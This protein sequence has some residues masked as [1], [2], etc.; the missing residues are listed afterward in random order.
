MFAA[1]YSYYKGDKNLV[2]AKGWLVKSANLNYYISARVL[3]EIY[4]SEKNST[5]AIIWYKKAALND[6][7]AS[8]YQLAMIYLNDFNNPLEACNYFRSTLAVAEKL[9]KLGDFVTSSDQKFVDNSRTGLAT[10]CS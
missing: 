7:I 10:F 1:G 6:D 9:T 2:E 8:T 4:R 5:E 3:G